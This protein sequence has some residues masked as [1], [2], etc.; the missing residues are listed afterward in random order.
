MVSRRERDAE[1]DPD[2]L[3]LCILFLLGALGDIVEPFPRNKTVPSGT[4]NLTLSCTSDLGADLVFWIFTPDISNQ[5]RKIAMGKNVY[6]DG[7]DLYFTKND[8]TS[9]LVVRSANE[10]TAGV[11]SCS[12]G[13]GEARA[14]LTISS[15]SRYFFVGYRM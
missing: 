12:D 10:S 13:L 9:N 6:Q 4:R 1:R 2:G 8:I 3:Y 5:T 11:Y 7:Y 15:N 14:Q